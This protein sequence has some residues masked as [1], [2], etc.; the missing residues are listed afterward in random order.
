MNINQIGPDIVD[1]YFTF[2]HL[3]RFFSLILEL[4]NYLFIYLFVHDP[5]SC[6]AQILTLFKE[7]IIIIIIV[8]KLLTFYATQS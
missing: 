2:I 1:I 8:R 5:T 6:N 7:V 3:S 4:C